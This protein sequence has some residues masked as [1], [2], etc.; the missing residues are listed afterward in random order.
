MEDATSAESAIEKEIRLALE[1]EE[2]MRREHEELVRQLA[3]RQQT[4]ATSS[5]ME[6]SS[7]SDLH[8]SFN[9]MTE[10][11]RGSRV[12]IR[13]NAAQHEDAEQE[14]AMQRASIPFYSQVSK[15]FLG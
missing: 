11:D 12:W 2:T 3:K 1:R 14:E 15:Y 4:A 5:S 8:A 13:G 9:E 7:D 6:S 10:A